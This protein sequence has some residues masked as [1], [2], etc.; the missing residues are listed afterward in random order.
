[1]TRRNSILVPIDGSATALRAL[2]HACMRVRGGENLS[3]IALNVQAP[4]PPSRFVTRAMIDGHRE[5]E[6]RAALKSARALAKRLGVPVD[7]QVLVGSAAPTIA[8]IAKA[9]RCTGIVMGT[10][11]LGRLPGFVLGSTAMRVVQLA[12]VPVTLVK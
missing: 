4:M 1:M 8:R 12:D 5:R 11:G 10:R 6:S 2:E 3:I 7:W 9:Q